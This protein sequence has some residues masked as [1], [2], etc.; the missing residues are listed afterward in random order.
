MARLLLS[1]LLS[2]VVAVL[3]T[4]ASLVGLES[5]QA[6]DNIVYVTDATSYWYVC[7]ELPDIV[8]ADWI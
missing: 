4:P 6:V 2:L 3:A 5:R 8:L 1:A 7:S